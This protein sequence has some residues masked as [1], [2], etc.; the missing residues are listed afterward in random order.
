M[1]NDAGAQ[2]APSNGDYYTSDS[3][4][5]RDLRRTA[6]N[7]ALE[8]ARLWM[9]PTQEKIVETAAAFYVFLATDIPLTT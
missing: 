8:A 5:Q 3:F 6:L 7:F 4:V 9:E 1:A 2:A